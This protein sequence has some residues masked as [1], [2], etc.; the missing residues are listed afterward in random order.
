[1]LPK[2]SNACD[3]LGEAYVEA[4]TKDLAVANYRRSLE[5]DPK[6]DNAIAMLKKRGIACKPAK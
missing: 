5:L 2:G 6:N 3:S 1:M 4:G